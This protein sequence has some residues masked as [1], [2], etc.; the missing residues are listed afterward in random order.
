MISLPPAIKPERY[1]QPAR[2][3]S[4][5]HFDESQEETMSHTQ[6]TRITNTRLDAVRST[7]GSRKEV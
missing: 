6:E 5:P 3:V 1:Q 4:F 2:D 7:G